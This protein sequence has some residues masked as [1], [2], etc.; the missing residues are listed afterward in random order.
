MTARALFTAL[1]VAAAASPTI[2][3]SAPVLKDALTAP[4]DFPIVANHRAAAII[5]DKADPDIVR[6]AADLLANDIARVAGV[7]PSVETLPAKPNESAIVIGTLGSPLIADLVRRKKLDAS[8]ITG[9][10]EAFIIATVADPFP[11]MPAALVIAGS[12]P[13]GAA[14]GALTISQTLGIS[15]WEWWADVPVIHRDTLVLSTGSGFTDRPAVKYRGIFINDED[16]GLQPWA[17][18]TFEPE[19][20]NIGPKTYTK[21]FELLLRLRANTIWPAMH[22]CTKAFHL[23]PGNAAI[24]DKY[25]IVLGSSHAEPMLRSN[26]SEWTAPKDDYNYLKNRDGVLAYWEQRVK[27]RS[28]GES[29]FTIGMRGI[30]DSPI[31]GPKTQPERI[32]TIEKIFKDQRDLLGRYLGKGDPTRVG[33]IYCPYKEVLDDYLAGL[34]VPDDVTIVYPDDNFGYVRRFATNAERKRSGGLGV[35]YHASYLGAPMQSLWIDTLPPALT[36]SEM[37]RAYE[38]GARSVWIVNTGDIKN[39]ERSTEFFLDLAWNA[40]RTS[41]DAPARFMRETAARDFGKEHAE[42]VADILNR[43]QAI[44]FARKTEHLQWHIPLT[45]YKPTELNEAEIDQRLK[46]C[47]KLLRD[48]DTLAQTLPAAA[49]DAYFEL[50]G[51]P[52]AI[53]AAANE[54]YFR[55]EL[56]RADDARGRPPKPNQDASAAAQKRILEATA[57][58]NTDIAGGKWRNIVTE[59]GVSANDWPR[60]QRDTKTVPPQPAPDNV[61]PPAPA[62]PSAPA[63]PKPPGEHSGDFVERDGVVSILAGHF[64]SKKDLPSGGWRAVPGLGRS[65]CAVTVLPSTSSIPPAA[66][67]S[68]EYRFHTTSAAPATLHVRL[69]PTHPLVA[70]HGLRFAIA[71][72][73]NPPLPLAVTNGFDPKSG[74]WNQRVLA[75]ATEVSLKLPN[76]LTADSHTLRLV[77]VDA[78]VVVDKIVIDLGGLQPSYDGP[79]ETRVP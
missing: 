54:R 38:Q 2:F 74:E 79:A 55:S 16:W 22:E 35:Y 72:D 45:A 43:L 78:G 34:K 5:V 75:N 10:W 12:D 31:V 65:G 4:S 67:P 3:A 9:R 61:C 59:N 18:R 17:A 29:L 25:A 44:N 6:I 46:A 20:K 62:A 71:I 64:A 7:K 33:Q 56:A 36:W 27:E 57:R 14:Y 15:P 37:E 53:T 77:A 24:A 52:V 13:R 50:V 1:C 70:E 23:V 40:D 63:S 48:S 49:R 8:P 11:G 41:I 58:Y 73:D 68:L 42:Q 66:A 60:F 76:N 32:V 51:Y 47:A 30:H 26:T 39:T 28:A 19:V 69:L 21:V